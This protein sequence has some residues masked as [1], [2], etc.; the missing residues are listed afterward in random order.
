VVPSVG[1]TVG[2][3]DGVAEGAADGSG[4]PV[5]AP[6]GADEGDAVGFFVGA[7]VPFLLFLGALVGAAV[8]FL[9][10]ALVFLDFF[11]IRRDCCPSAIM[12]ALTVMAIKMAARMVVLYIMMWS[13]KY[14]IEN[15]RLCF[16]SLEKGFM[17]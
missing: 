8:G 10:G 5:G 11:N 14:L 9:V 15:E 3:V 2:E 17:I 16:M 6:E 13:S 1:L 12:S 7:G 4:V